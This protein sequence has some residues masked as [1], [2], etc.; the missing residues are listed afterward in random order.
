MQPRGQL[1]ERRVR[2]LIDIGLR[3]VS[4][5]DPD[6]VLD[7]IITDGMELTGARFGALGVLNAKRDGL[8]RFITAGMDAATI[9]S[10]GER[11]EGRGILKKTD[12]SAN[13]EAMREAIEETQRAAGE[14]RSIIADLH[15]A[16]PEELGAETNTHVVCSDVPGIKPEDV[17][18]EVED[19][20]LTVS[21]E[22]EDHEE[23]KDKHCVR[24][25][26]RYGSLSCRWPSLRAWIRARSRPARVARASARPRLSSAVR[27]DR[28]G[29][30][31]LPR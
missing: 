4:E 1:D 25:E 29:R 15:P 31:P 18:I 13:E 16:S 2:R 10:I 11:P 20:I 5:L 14:L 7:R 17:N 8:E 22:H 12:P 27:Y 21:G 3:L 19:E 23:K 24:R 28:P 26:R 30:R 6:A 9:R